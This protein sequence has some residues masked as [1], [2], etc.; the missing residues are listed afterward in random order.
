MP[1]QDRLFTV[2]KSLG[3]TLAAP[4]PPPLAPRSVPIY[5]D[6]PKP[7]AGSPLPLIKPKAMAMFNDKPVEGGITFAHLDKLPRLPIPELERTCQRYL[8]ALRPRRGA[9]GRAGA[10]RAGQD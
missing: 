5:P 10:G 4:I 1:T 9:R 6:I 3:E 7:S 8:A 2:P